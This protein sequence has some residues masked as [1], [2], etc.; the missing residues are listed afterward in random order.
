MDAVAV[1]TGA[2]AGIGEAIARRLL[3]EGRTVIALQRRPPRLRHARLLYREA[4]L[5]DASA[6]A[7]VANELAAEFPIRYLVNNAGTNRPGL[8]EDA[9]TDDLD[10]V[11]ALNVRAA[12]TL[13][14]SFTPDMR[15]AKFGR[16]VNMSSRAV[17]G[18]TSRTVYSP[19]KQR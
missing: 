8:L 9:T 1:V 4:D 10:Y 6:G 18:K 15:K 19:Q 13:I 12:M 5:A 16:I 11:M 7:D 3:E 14:K 17:L 2:S